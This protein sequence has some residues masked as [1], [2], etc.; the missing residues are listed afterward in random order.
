MIIIIIIIINSM[1]KLLCPWR[2]LLC[3]TRLNE[4]HGILAFINK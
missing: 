4:G 3:Y 2:L 1:R